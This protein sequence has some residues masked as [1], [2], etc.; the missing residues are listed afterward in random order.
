ME[1]TSYLGKVF[2]CGD[3]INFIETINKTYG[4]SSFDCSVIKK[5]PNGYI[6]F[7]HIVGKEYIYNSI[8][9]S[10]VPIDSTIP[11]KIQKILYYNYIA[12]ST[13]IKNIERV[14]KSDYPILTLPGAMFL[15]GEHEIT[16]SNREITIDPVRD[17]TTRCPENVHLGVFSFYKALFARKHEYILKKDYD[18]ILQILLNTIDNINE[19]WAKLV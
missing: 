2:I 18:K 19:I 6:M 11:V 14:D 7:R 17:I 16:L 4:F 5:R 9:N 8:I 10:C 3:Q 15:I 1:G 13:E 12:C